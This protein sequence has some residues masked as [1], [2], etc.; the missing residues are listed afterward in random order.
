MH[1][2]PYIV[3]FVNTQF[4]LY[5]I[6]EEPFAQTIPNIVVSGW[7][8]LARVLICPYAFMAPVIF[9]RWDH[10]RDQMGETQVG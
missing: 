8:L 2:F 6:S 7:Y 3:P 10:D 5:F 9:K 1:L 4:S